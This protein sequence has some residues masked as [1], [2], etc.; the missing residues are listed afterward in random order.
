VLDDEEALDAAELETDDTELPDV[1][2]T[3]G[4]PLSDPPPHPAMEH[5][6]T[7]TAA[8]QSTL[9][10]ARSYCAADGRRVKLA[11][12][13]MPDSVELTTG[14]APTASVIWLHG[15]GADGH[16]FEPIVPE[17]QAFLPC[18]T[19]FVFPHA[20][21][22]RVTING[23]Y[24]MRAWYDILSFDRAAPQDLAGIQESHRAVLKLIERENG[25]GIG[26]DRIVLA[27]FSQGGAMALYSGVRLAQPLAGIM[28]L[29][30]YLLEP[31]RFAIERRAVTLDAPVFLAHGESDN[32]LP[33]ELG[34]RAR[35]QVA[36][37]G[38]QVEWHRYAMAHS[39][40]PQEIADIGRWLAQVLAA[41]REPSP[42]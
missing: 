16:D 22:R 24:S 34:E 38:Y 10:I 18:D 42:A 30:C 28:G 7:I 25:R 21:V 2:V 13:M 5:R 40:V 36:A 19:R 32:V 17:L 33:V 3:G 15:L 23:G 26:T 35:D 37:A 9:N 14:P 12:S 29:S 8:R 1:L 11:E 31:A 41:R 39:V 4:V 6:E 27:G 20:P